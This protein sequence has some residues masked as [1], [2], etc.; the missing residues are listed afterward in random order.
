MKKIPPLLY[1]LGLVLLVIG[2]S[3][4][5]SGFG[6]GVNEQGHDMTAITIGGMLFSM[7]MMVIAG[8]FYMSA[9]NIDL[10][11]P[12]AQTSRTE[13]TITSTSRKFKVGNCA[14]CKNNPAIVRCMTHM[15]PLCVSC[16]MKHDN[17][18]NCEYIPM[19]RKAPKQPGSQRW[20]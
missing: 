17:G 7:G 15:A 10:G 13:T 9:A 20:G 6:K 5:I 11:P 2:I 19:A 12:G 3:G 16:M 8:G 4:L 18:T 14:V 1:V